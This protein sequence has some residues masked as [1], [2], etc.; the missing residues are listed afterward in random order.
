MARTRLPAAVMAMI[1]ADE[2]PRATVMR[3]V[4]P[5]P[6]SVNNMFPTIV[7]NGKVRRI[8][9]KAGKDFEAAVRNVVGLWINH[10][11]MQPPAPPYALKLV[12]W[13]PD[14]SH[15]HDLTNLFKAPEDALMAAIGGDDNDVL[16]VV[17]TKLDADA[18]PRIELTLETVR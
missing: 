2:R 9:S 4:L 13:P 8:K 18:H 3:L 17:G 10:H 15:K 14:D 5:F 16:V 7:V 11:Q 12:V 1:P 6:P